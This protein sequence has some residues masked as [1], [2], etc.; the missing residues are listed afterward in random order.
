MGGRLSKLL[1]QRRDTRTDRAMIPCSRI[2]RTIEFEPPQSCN[3][4]K[5]LEYH[6]LA[7]Q[8]FRIPSIE[9]FTTKKAKNLD[10]GNPHRNKQNI[11]PPWHIFLSLKQCKEIE[12]KLQKNNELL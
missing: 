11:Y 4:G 8:P 1:C 6:A 2:E 5:P 10:M 9:K 12:K 3:L 7:G